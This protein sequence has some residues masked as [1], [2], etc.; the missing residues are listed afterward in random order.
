MHVL[1]LTASVATLAGEIQADERE[2]RA[3][4]A[5][6]GYDVLRAVGVHLQL[7]DKCALS[8]S[9]RQSIGI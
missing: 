2:R 9:T 7:V 8:I 6:L 4:R 5:R 1:H 3:Y